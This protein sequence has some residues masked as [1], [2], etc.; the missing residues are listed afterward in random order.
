M[1]LQDVLT[2]YQFKNVGQFRGIAQSLGYSE[3]YN[4]GNLR[5]TCGDDEFRTSVD[6]IR[7]YTEREQD[8]P[9]ES[10]SMERIC[11]FF[12]REQALM[13]EYKKTLSK[14][15]VDIINWG[16]LK[17]DVKDRF[18][19]IDHTNK[20]CYTGKELYEYALQNSY[21]LD[22]KGTQ[23]EKGVL[24]ELTEI[25][26][27]PAKVRLTENGVSI[28][29]RK[30]TLAIPDSLFGKK[31]SKRQQQDL[32]NGNVIVLSSK[33]GDIFLQVDKDLNAVVVRSEKELSIPARIGGYEL[34]PADKYLMA[35]GF[36]LDNKIMK[37]DDGYFIA[38]VALNA[39][40]KGFSFSN[41]QMI[42]ETK[43]KELLQTREA[44]RDKEYINDKLKALQR[45]GII[46]LREMEDKRY[47]QLINDHF[48]AEYKETI[49]YL[50][51][52][53][54]DKIY[55]YDIE[56]CIRLKAG[57][58]LEKED[59]LLKGTTEN[60]LKEEGFKVDVLR[61]IY[62]N[63]DF[64]KELK[65]AVSK[66]DYEK[67]SQ[68][69]DE[70][71]KPSEEVIKGLGKDSK[72]DEKQAVAIEAL[73]GIKPEVS[74]DR[75]KFATEV[76]QLP[77]NYII[78]LD[79]PILIGD[80]ITSLEKLEIDVSVLNDSFPSDIAKSE[81]VDTLFLMVDNGKITDWEPQIKESDYH[82]PIK[83]Y[84]DL[85]IDKNEKLDFSGRDLSFKTA[86]ESNDF[87]KLSQLKEQG[88]QP[89]KELL[90][91][92]D[93]ISGNTKIAVQ[94]IFGLKA[95]SPAVMNDVKL[96]QSRPEKDITRPLTNTINRAFSDL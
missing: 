53:D 13:P 85:E 92:L 83:L 9:S 68:L 54:P 31:L 26:G 78:K 84:S 89:S 18:T 33:K 52:D 43:A 34:T 2:E 67:M 4:N 71:Y 3:E 27:K 77:E 24:S 95:A 19:I 69:K 32:L 65:E 48:S 66:N 30:E 28:H 41:I 75:E 15:G 44:I 56:G 81:K 80:L 91:S 59:V 63:R 40:K 1:N 12:D 55:N 70:G 36:S 51:D 37:G 82:I 46:D 29:Y 5:F 86:I 61:E 38:D 57:D 10:R 21:I 94:K 25:K 76:E 74:Q 20:I 45:S 88:Y 62:F 93:S 79:K 7:S 47:E 23:L 11:K 17:G 42:S 50:K 87:E 35:N 49:S 39:D 14:E 58:I 96:A 6:K 90:E 73:F 8:L 22:G 64:E 60:E 16:D 72:I